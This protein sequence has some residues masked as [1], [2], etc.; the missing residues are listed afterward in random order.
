MPP[1]SQ[2]RSA[3]HKK[4]FVVVRNFV[5]KE[6]CALL[7][8][9]VDQQAPLE[10]IESTPH[11]ATGS[12]GEYGTAL[13]DAL[14]KLLVPRVTAIVGK[15]VVPTFSFLRI[16]AA[17]E[18]LKTHRDR[19]ACEICVSLNFAHWTDNKSDAPGSWPLFCNNEPV[20]CRVADAILF[21]G[22]HVKHARSP[23][24]G[25]NCG[26]LMLHYVYSDSEHRDEERDRRDLL[27]T[28][29]EYLCREIPIP[30][31]L[32]DCGIGAEDWA[33]WRRIC[34][35]AACDKE[36]RSRLVSEPIDTMREFNLTWSSRKRPQ[37]LCDH[38][39]HLTLVV[40][41]SN[42]SGP[43]IDGCTPLYWR[44]W[45]ATRIWKN[46][47]RVV[48][49][50]AIQQ[51]VDRIATACLANGASTYIQEQLRAEIETRLEIEFPF[52]S[53]TILK[54]TTSKTVRIVI[55]T[56]DSLV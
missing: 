14:L 54:E 16:Y 22:I 42:N 11:A 10:M 44:R 6:T 24:T 41:T 23:L 40:S 43:L 9:F 56:R 37:L 17:G 26:I 34:F 4:G 12:Y 45:V 19:N 51:I 21:D 27:G 25:P 29:K 36:F 28:S 50:A 20:I 46:S 33:V 13:G 32:P 30:L 35:V 31:I 1:N 18:G 53:F 55:P 15:A 47:R 52:K 38:D 49:R 48:R 5:G 7:K 3:F 39:N 8:E 2:I